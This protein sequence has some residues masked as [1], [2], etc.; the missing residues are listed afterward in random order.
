MLVWRTGFACYFNV[1]VEG[2]GEAFQIVKAHQF[3][4]KFVQA[5]FYS[6]FLRSAVCDSEDGFFFC[7]F[8]SFTCL[9]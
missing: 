9:I 7:N 3:A 2:F 6:G 4:G 1:G 5:F 8:G